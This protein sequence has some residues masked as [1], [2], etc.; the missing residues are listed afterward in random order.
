MFGFDRPPE[1]QAGVSDVDLSGT[2]ALITGSTSGIGKEAAYALGRLGAR[3][4]VHG[5]DREAGEAVVEQ[6]EETA[7]TAQ[8][9]R[10]DFFYPEQIERLATQVAAQSDGLDILCHNAGG[11]FETTGPT[12]LG[13]DPAFHVNHLGPYLLTAELLPQLVETRIVTTASIAHRGTTLGIDQL[14]ELSGLSPVS[15][16]CRSKLANV[17]FAAELSRRLTAVDRQSTSNSFHPGVI[18][19]SEFGRSFPGVGT[20]LWQL[21][22]TTPLFESVEEGAATLVY[23]AASPE[24]AE[25]TGEYFARRRSIRPS[26]QA[27]D[28][29]AQRELWEQSAKL[30]DIE[31]PL[32]D[33]V[34]S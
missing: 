18:P 8:F 3:V 2:T 7:G 30:L 29:H 22:D 34:S 17:Q 19:G 12:E 16:Y 5:R 11:F 28:E 26:P 24:V 14:F 27:R 9:F 6:I 25:T 23:L 31:E 20:E 13:V 21:F 4:F 10:A 33:A 32:A 15:A 1:E